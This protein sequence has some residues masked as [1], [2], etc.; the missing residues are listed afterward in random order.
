MD[1]RETIYVVDTSVLMSDPKVFFRLGCSQIVIPLAVI[2]ELDGLK[3]S[4]NSVRA[5]AARRVTLI[6]DE[7]GSCQN[8]V[9][10]AKTSSGSVVRIFGRY[11]AIDGL[12]SAADNQI[13]GAALS[14][15]LDTVNANVIVLTKDGNMRNVTRAYGIKAENYPLDLNIVVDNPNTKTYSG[16]NPSLTEKAA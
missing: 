4:S 15:K 8:M 9:S 12:A 3:K 11:L 1:T 10:G 2:R 14:L 7:L 16:A 13:V 5:S 6:L